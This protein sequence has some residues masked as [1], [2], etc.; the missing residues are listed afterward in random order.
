MR[1]LTLY[2][3]VLPT[4]GIYRWNAKLIGAVTTEASFSI[5]F[6]DY[7]SYN[8]LLNLISYIDFYFTPTYTFY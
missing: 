4:G 8:Q 2:T 7:A 6:S 5:S 1:S 3:I